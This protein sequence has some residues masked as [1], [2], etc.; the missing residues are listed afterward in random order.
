VK[1][2]NQARHP[3]GKS[4][5]EAARAAFRLLRG[6][7]DSELMLPPQV[8]RRDRAAGAQLGATDDRVSA[9][10]SVS[11]RLNSSAIISAIFDDFARKGTRFVRR[12]AVYSTS[13]SVTRNA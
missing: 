5:A 7:L 4:F 2:G 10:S 6:P 9:R 11:T 13:V 3:E 8:L 12:R 1:F